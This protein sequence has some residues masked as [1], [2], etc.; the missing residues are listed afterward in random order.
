MKQRLCR[1]RWESITR[2][3]ETIYFEEIQL[4]GRT[5]NQMRRDNGYIVVRV[6]EGVHRILPLVFAQQNVITIPIKELHKAKYT[7]FESTDWTVDGIDQGK[8][9]THSIDEN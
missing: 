6:P 3:S 8:T 7:T 4:D 9:K 2:Q 1:Q 5:T